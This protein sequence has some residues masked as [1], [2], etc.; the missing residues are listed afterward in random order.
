M[1]DVLRESRDLAGASLERVRDLLQKL[2]LG[3]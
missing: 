2:G 3:T 1:E